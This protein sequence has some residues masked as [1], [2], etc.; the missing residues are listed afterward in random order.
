MLDCVVLRPIVSTLLE[1]CGGIKMKRIAWLLACSL[2]VPVAGHAQECE[3]KNPECIAPV[4][5]GGG[6]DLTCRLT[7]Q[8][9][10]E[11]GIVEPTIRTTNMPG[12]IGAVAYNTIQAQRADDPNVIIAVS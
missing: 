5:P 10:N 11:F 12:G 1:G 9:L 8:K 3:P 4:A 6:F 7:S 2:I